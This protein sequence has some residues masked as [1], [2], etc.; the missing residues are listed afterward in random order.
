LACRKTHHLHSIHAQNAM[1][2]PKRR[3]GAGAPG[4]HCT[5]NTL[6]LLAPLLT[7]EFFP[8]NNGDNPPPP[9]RPMSVVYR[10]PIMRKPRLVMGIAAFNSLVAAGL[11][12]S[13][14]NAATPAAAVVAKYDKDN[15]KTLDLAEVK[16]AAAA[17]FDQL[18]KDSD[19]TLDA[20]EVKGVI[21][22]RTFKAADPD[23]D[24]TLDKDEY[25]ALVAKLFDKADVDHDGTIDAK[26][27]ASKSGHALRRLID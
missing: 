19:N 21:G 12:M 13:S 17:H 15:D 27:L 1:P 16:A 4:P 9:R 25:L 11:V 22:A 24:G 6:R 10:N 2:G 5:I 23:N 18:N 26:E 14:A 8:Y 3:P 7:W 20:N